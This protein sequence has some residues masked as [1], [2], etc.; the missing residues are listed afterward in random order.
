MKRG[1]AA[2]LVVLGVVG[3]LGLLAYLLVSPFVGAV[4]NLIEDLPSIVESVRQSDI[5]QQID[6]RTDIGEKL[7]QRAE[8]LASDLPSKLGDGATAIGNA[9]VALAEGPISLSY[10]PAGVLSVQNVSFGGTYNAWYAEITHSFMAVAMNFGQWGSVG[11]GMTVLTT[12][13]SFHQMVQ[14]A[15]LAWDAEPDTQ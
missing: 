9:Q 10:N 5:F 14:D 12:D 7:Q 4:R 15:T 8:S 2:M 6:Q 1:N 13:G 3:F 11:L